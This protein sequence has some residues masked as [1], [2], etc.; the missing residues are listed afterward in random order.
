MTAVN[1]KP[2]LTLVLAYEGGFVNHP[3]DP[4]GATNKGVT[5]KVYDDY[6]LSRGRS[7]RSVKLIEDLEVAAIFKNNYWD[8][9]AC[10]RLPAGLDFAVFDFAVNS[11]VTRASKFLQAILG[12][13]NVDGI[14]GQATLALADK[15]AGADE[16]GLIKRYCAE[17]LEFL[18]SLSTFDVFGVGWT[19]RVESVTKQACMI[20]RADLTFSLPAPVGA[21]PGEAKGKALPAATDAPYMPSKPIPYGELAAGRWHG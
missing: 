14:I 18:Q 10:D 20:A 6:R 11:G 19:R 21:L 2:G 12:S 3:R 15:F 13:N 17:R 7:I 1:F 5:Q 8:R 9:A 16:E 4:G